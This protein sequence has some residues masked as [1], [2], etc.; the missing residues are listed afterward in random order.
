MSNQQKHLYGAHIIF[1]IFF[2]LYLIINVVLIWFCVKPPLTK[3]WLSDAF[4]AGLI[5]GGFYVL[6]AIYYFYNNILGPRLKKVLEAK[7]K[8]KKQNIYGLMMRWFI[9]PLVLQCCVILLL[10]IT[11]YKS[12]FNENIYIQPYK[13]GKLFKQVED[14]S[15]AVPDSVNLTEEKINQLI[16][17]KKLLVQT[18]SNEIIKQGANTNHPEYIIYRIPFFIALAFSFLGVLVYSLMDAAFRLHARDLYPRTF[19]SY[20]VRFLLALTLS[21][22]IAYFFMDD[23]PVS[24]AA[25]LFFFIGFFPQRALQYLEEKAMAY[26]KLKKGET[27]EVPL[28]R[29]QGMTDYKI[30]RFREIGAGDAQNLAFID[31]NYLK[32]NLSYNCR[33][34]CD[35]VSQALLI[36][37]VEEHLEALRK[38]GIRDIFSFRSIVTKDNYE[39][40]ADLTKIPKEILFGLLDS[41]KKDPIKKRIKIISELIEESTIEEISEI[42]Y[43]KGSN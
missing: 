9:P 3:P 20:L 38:M 15:Q 1:W 5:L 41:I 32:E 40:I 17:S 19:V 14:F 10:L 6:I 36:I 29:I 31:I 8:Y 42:I 2:A 39:Q 4:F 21:I 16:A 24:M 22:T 30:Y 13:F 12:P 37:H 7:Q 18:Y 25:P 27:K 26:L 11:V 43:S 28:N 23:W 34:L 33:L 35:F